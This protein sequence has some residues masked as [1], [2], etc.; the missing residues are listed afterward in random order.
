M[1]FSIRFCTT[2]TSSSQSPSTGIGAFDG[3]LDL[4]AALLRKARQ[5][6]ADMA[7]DLRE[8]DRVGRPLMRVHLDA[9]QRQ[10]IV[11]QPPH[12][13]GLRAHQIEEPLARHLVVLGRALQRLD[14]AEQRGERGAQFMAGIG[15]EIGAH[16][17]DLL[18]ARQVAQQDQRGRL[19]GFA[20]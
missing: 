16:A 14:E 13:L 6:V 2:C 18:L 3:D 11:D 12:A 20:R 10:E 17:L 7:R 9:A 8:V 4:H 1:A 15:D 5:H 19:A